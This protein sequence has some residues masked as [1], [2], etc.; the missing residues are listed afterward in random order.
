[1]VTLFALFILYRL[2]GIDT[3]EECRS[4]EVGMLTLLRQYIPICSVIS[5]KT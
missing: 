1:M 4:K 2:G 5:L 3:E